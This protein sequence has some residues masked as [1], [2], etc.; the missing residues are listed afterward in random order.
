MGAGSG[1]EV[2]VV[3]RFDLLRQ[4][5]GSVLGLGLNDTVAVDA[6]C[7]T[8]MYKL[9]AYFVKAVMALRAHVL[10]NIEFWGVKN[11]TR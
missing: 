3:D 4:V 8:R 9:D 1:R 11:S 5:I 2:P 7:L 10:E 6:L